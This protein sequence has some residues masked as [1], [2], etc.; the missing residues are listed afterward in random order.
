MDSSVFSARGLGGSGAPYVVYR[1]LNQRHMSMECVWMCLHVCKCS[2]VFTWVCTCC[3]GLRGFLRWIWYFKAEI[4][5]QNRWYFNDM[6]M[7]CLLFLL[8]WR[9]KEASYRAFSLSQN[10]PRVLLWVWNW[11]R[12]NSLQASGFNLHTDLFDVL[13]WEQRK[14]LLSQPPSS[15]LMAKVTAPG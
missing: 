15:L 9:K 5:M 2:D 1:H 10:S 13:S 14:E 12:V 4:E 11:L 3:M 7:A 8:Q 6:L